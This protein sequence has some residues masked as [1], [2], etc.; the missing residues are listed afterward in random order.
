MKHREKFIATNKDIDYLLRQLFEDDDHDYPHEVMRVYLGVSLSLFSSSG[1]RAGAVVEA[2]SYRG[3]NECLYYK[4]CMISFNMAYFHR[5]K[6]V[7]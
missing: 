2:S 1:S 7:D 6:L 3:T 5:T 4:V